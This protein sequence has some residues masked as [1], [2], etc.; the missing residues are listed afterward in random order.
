MGEGDS[1]QDRSGTVLIVE[2][3]SLTCGGTFRL[4]AVRNDLRLWRDDKPI[5]ANN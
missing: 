1:L 2:R 3:V 4:F 5:Y